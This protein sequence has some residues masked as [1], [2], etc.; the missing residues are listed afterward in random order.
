M[1]LHIIDL[2]DAFA[3]LAI[4]SVSEYFGFR[5]ELTLVGNSQILVDVLGANKPFEVVLINGHGSEGAFHLPELSD[6]IKDQYPYGSK[7]SHSELASFLKIKA[8]CVISTA[9]SSGTEDMANVFLAG[10]ARYFIAPTGYP[11]GSDAL[12]LA[13]DFLYH[14][15]L[16]QK[17]PVEALS[18]AKFKTN[19]SCMFNVWERDK[20]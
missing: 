17:T 15:G 14:Y 20:Q 13:C 19:D 12:K 1:H 2:D 18:L 8:C 16:K 5:T 6:E 7:L 10:G 4:R 11:D 9:C 3:S